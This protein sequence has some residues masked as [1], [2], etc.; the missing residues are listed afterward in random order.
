MLLIII[1]TYI[2]VPPEG[3]DP[4]DAES[5]KENVHLFKA[6]H[7][8]VPLIAHAFGSLAGAFTTAKIAANKKFLFA[9]LIGVFHLLGGIGNVYM[10]PAPT[11][12]IVVD[13]A[14]AYLPMAYLGYKIAS[15]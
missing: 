8:I 12:F 2:I 10:M 15:K 13:L 3:V 14:L 5:I 4:M 7:Y 9:M 11:W 6:K 1:G